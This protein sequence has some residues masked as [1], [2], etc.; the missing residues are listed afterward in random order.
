MGNA[1]VCVELVQE[2]MRFAP[3]QNSPITQARLVGLLLFVESILD[4]FLDFFVA[5]RTNYFQ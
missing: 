1:Q 4:G 2:W 5:R 3:Q